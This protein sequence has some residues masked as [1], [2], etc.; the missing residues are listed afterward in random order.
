MEKLKV[1]E[2]YYG[3]LTL[4]IDKLKLLFFWTRSE[5]ANKNAISC[6]KEG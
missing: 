6:Y 3:L 2:E 5:F 1:K 4:N